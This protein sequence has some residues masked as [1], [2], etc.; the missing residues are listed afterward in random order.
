MNT[1][2]LRNFAYMET[3]WKWTL[4]ELKTTTATDK[5][6]A[7]SGAITLVSAVY[8]CSLLLMTLSISLSKLRSKNA[9]DKV[10]QL[11]ADTEQQSYALS[12]AADSDIGAFQLFLASFD[13]PAD[14]ESHKKLRREEIVQ[15]RLESIR[16]PLEAAER[17][18]GLYSI[19]FDAIP[20][21]SKNVLPDLASCANIFYSSICNLCWNVRVNSKKLSPDAR[22]RL[23]SAA[24][25]HKN[26]AKVATKLI[27]KQVAK[28]LGV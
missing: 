21:V 16:I 9:V 3:I 12:K 26:D 15:H 11:L 25:L 2:R 18:T 17:I 24:G 14:T 19:I 5:P 13:L 1:I 8:G 28:M 22:I 23:T 4:D 27:N 7:T 6:V 20:L 10:R